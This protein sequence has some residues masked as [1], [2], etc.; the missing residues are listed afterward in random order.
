MHSRRPKKLSSR[1]RSGISLTEF[2]RE[3]RK[4]PRNGYSKRE[5]SKISLHSANQTFA[6]FLDKHERLVKVAFGI[7]AQHSSII[8]SK[9][10]LRRKFKNQEP[11]EN[12]TH[13]HIVTHLE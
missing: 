2:A 11:L 5:I 13:D 12:S 4:L 6:D 10:T 8:S 9:M 3:K 1:E 7:A